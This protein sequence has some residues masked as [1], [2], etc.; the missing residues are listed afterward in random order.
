MN[1]NQVTVP[2]VDVERSV[3][4]Y[5]LLGLRLIVSSLPRYARLE[6][7][8]GEGTFSIHQV[9]SLPV[10]HGV[11]VYFECEDLDD[12][13]AD[14]QARG[15][16]IETLPVD[17]PWLWREASLKDPDGNALILFWAGSNRK[18]P[19]WRIGMTAT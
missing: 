18:N 17:Q 19:P 7:P 4:F 6:C 8:D 15:V 10:G 16:K 1:L 5:A 2:S 11:V 12:R 3:E 13:I 9:E 14:L